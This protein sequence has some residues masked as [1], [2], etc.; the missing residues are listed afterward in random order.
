MRAG[1]KAILSVSYADQPGANPG[2]ATRKNMKEVKVHYSGFASILVKEMLF[3]DGNV[4]YVVEKTDLMR[5]RN[6]KVLS[7]KTF[8][9]LCEFLK[10]QS[11]KKRKGERRA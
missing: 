6:G 5:N 9:D 11:A 10:K 3:S 1:G 4:R 8:D 2:P 7:F